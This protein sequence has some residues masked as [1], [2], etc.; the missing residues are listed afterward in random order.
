M[1]LTLPNKLGGY[2]LPRPE[3]NARVVP[4]KT[5]GKFS[6]RAFYTCDLF[7]PDHGLAVEYD[8]TQFHTGSAH[9]ADDSRKRNSLALMGVKVITVTTRQLYDERDFEKATSIIAKCLCKRLEYKN[10]GFTAAHMEL[11][12]RLL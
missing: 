4:S 3:L 8:S 7:W 6:T 5:A 1:L 11:R 12:S 9:I 2:G 10:P